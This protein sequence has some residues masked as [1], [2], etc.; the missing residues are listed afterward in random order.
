MVSPSPYCKHGRIKTKVCLKGKKRCDAQRCI[1][2]E[3]NAKAKRESESRL[4][5]S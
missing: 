4:R 3:L 5:L 2:Y 1:Y